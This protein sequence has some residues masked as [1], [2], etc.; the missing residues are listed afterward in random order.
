MSWEAVSWQDLDWESIYLISFLVGF[1]LSAI[2]FLAGALHFPHAHFHGHGH[3]LGKIGGK[4]VGRASVSFFNLGTAS[5]FLA[6]FGGTGYL[7]ERYS[8]IWVYLGLFVAIVSGL[9][10]ATLVFWFLAKL[11][12]HDQPLDPADYEMVGVLGRVASPIRKNGTG[13]ILYTRDGARKATPART[14]TGDEFSRDT[15]VIVTRYE[16]GIAF[17]RRWEDIP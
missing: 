3:G 14:D 8:D 9:A 1:L 2:S 10:G 17:V 4:G 13:E 5:A 12:K 11:A 6:W 7:L 16:K 15:E